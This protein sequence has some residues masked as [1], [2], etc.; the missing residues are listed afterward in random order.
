MP[1]VPLATQDDLEDATSRTFTSRQAAMALRR[2]S[3][4]VRKYCRYPITLTENETVLIEGGTRELWLP[5][6][7]VV[8][9]GTHPLVVTE[10]F[11][12]TSLEIVAV[13]GRDF[14]RLDRVLTRGQPWWQPNRFMGWPRMRQQGVWADR[15]RVLRSHGYTE[16]PDDILDIVL[17]LATLNVTNPGA[18][19][20]ESVDDYSRTFA[21]ET[22][23]GAQLT[24]DQKDALKPYRG[25][26]AFSV[27][28][29]V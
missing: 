19:R 17:A 29:E 28:L 15:V 7:P 2:A 27:R 10:L 21:A 4:R 9:D 23:G 12:M 11:G 1:L 18:L 26:G 25:S 13:E 6:G 3:A 5:G 22:I 8:V 14:T 20:Q 24:Q 16:V